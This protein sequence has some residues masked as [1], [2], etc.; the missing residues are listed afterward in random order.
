[1]AQFRVKKIEGGIIRLQYFPRPKICQR[2]LEI[3]HS[4][5]RDWS[6]EKCLRHLG[7]KMGLRKVPEFIPPT[8]GSPRGK[9]RE[10][11]NLLKNNCPDSN[12]KIGHSDCRDLPSSNLNPGPPPGKIIIL[13][14]SLKIA[15]TVKNSRSLSS[16]VVPSAHKPPYH[17]GGKV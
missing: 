8:A 4:V 1:V 5:I 10:W 12:F 14:P 2:S 3:G 7:V 13:P 11:N 15:R 16:I 6:S 9:N 17:K